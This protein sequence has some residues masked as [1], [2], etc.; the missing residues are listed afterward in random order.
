MF[1]HAYRKQPYASFLQTHSIEIKAAAV[2]GL[3]LFGGAKGLQVSK[4]KEIHLCVLAY[5]IG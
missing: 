3:W 4:Q 2:H 1:F 5:E